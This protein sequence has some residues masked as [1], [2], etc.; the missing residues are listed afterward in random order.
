M[1]QLVLMEVATLTGL[2]GEVTVICDKEEANLLSV[3]LFYEIVTGNVLRM[4]L[5]PVKGLRLSRLSNAKNF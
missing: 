3:N 5:M 2:E 4:K 1:K